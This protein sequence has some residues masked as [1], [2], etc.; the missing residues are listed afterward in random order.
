M[1]RTWAKRIRRL[2]AR[3]LARALPRTALFRYGY[4]KCL[5]N[6][7]SGERHVVVSKTEPTALA[8]VERCEFE[9]RVGPAPACAELNFIVHLS[10]EDETES[11]TERNS[12]QSITL[13]QPPLA[14]H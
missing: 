10:L 4:V 12:S 14:L 13:K 5:P 11:S 7:S 9:E 2:K 1:S 6:D 8:N 3:L